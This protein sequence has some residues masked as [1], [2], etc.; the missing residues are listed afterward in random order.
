[1]EFINDFHNLVSECVSFQNKITNLFWGSQFFRR[2]VSIVIGRETKTH[3]SPKKINEQK[4]AKVSSPNNNYS[5]NIIN[6]STITTTTPH[7]IAMDSSAGF[8]RTVSI[9]EVPRAAVSI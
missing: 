7:G 2:K 3:K 4:F 8:P 6:H 5:F 1:M 9:Y